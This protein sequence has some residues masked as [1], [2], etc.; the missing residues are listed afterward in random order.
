MNKYKYKY[1][2]NNKPIGLP[3]TEMYDELLTQH[4]GLVEGV[5][6]ELKSYYQRLQELAGSLA[7]T[8][9][10]LSAQTLSREIEHHNKNNPLLLELVLVFHEVVNNNQKCKRSQ[11]LSDYQKRLLENW[12]VTLGELKQKFPEPA[13]GNAQVNWH[14]SLGLILG[15]VIMAPGSE[16]GEV[17]MDNE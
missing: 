15:V 13:G 1:G 3:G 17:F 11:N 10:P 8:R 9:D 14:R 12:E 5:Q 16:K 7:S 6:T 4:T 2:A